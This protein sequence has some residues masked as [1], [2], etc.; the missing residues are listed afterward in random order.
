ML[1]P[2]LSGCLRT[3]NRTTT[4]L[5]VRRGSEVALA[6]DGQATEGSV[7]AKANVRKVR[8]IGGG[9]VMVGFAGSTADCFAMISL[10]ESKLEQYPDQ[11]LRAAVELAK[12]WRTDKLLRHLEAAMIAVD[13][14]TAITIYGNGDVMSEH[15][16][17]VMSIG[18][19][20]HFASSAARALIA[21][22]PIVTGTDHDGVQR[23]ISLSASDIAL[24]AMRIAADLDTHSNHNVTLEI[25]RDGHILSQIKPQGGELPTV[26]AL[27]NSEQRLERVLQQ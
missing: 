16:D 3:S 11:L 6:G 20:G 2:S 10:L 18:S 4:I 21:L 19:G 1:S 26:P 27:P 15:Q 9:K 14:H 7:V 23:R 12:D 24:K 13:A 5:A 8:V 25:L 22:P 17:G